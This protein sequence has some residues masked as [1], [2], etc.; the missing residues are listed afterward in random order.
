M[1]V[2][3]VCG[4]T[5]VEA[6]AVSESLDCYNGAGEGIIFG[7][8]ILD[9]YLQGFPGA[10]VQAEQKLP[11]IEKITA[12]DLL[13]I[14]DEMPM[15]PLPVAPRLAKTSPPANARKAGQRMDKKKTLFPIAPE[16]GQVHQTCLSLPALPLWASR[17][18]DQFS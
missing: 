3:R 17:F 8:Y 12:K 18:R 13:D 14:E 5:A 9:E 6:E 7:N 1:R 15:I 16:A 2:D 4:L 11:V 10:A